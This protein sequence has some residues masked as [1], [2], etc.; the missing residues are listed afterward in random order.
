MY[1][2]TCDLVLLVVELVSERTDNV[3]CGHQLFAFVFFQIPVTNPVLERRIVP[4][5]HL[6]VPHCVDNRPVVAAHLHW[7]LRF[8]RVVV[9]R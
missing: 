8:G 4:V 9:N 6:A 2:L 5:T 7:Q 1:N 3:S